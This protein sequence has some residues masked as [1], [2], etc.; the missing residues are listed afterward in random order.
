MLFCVQDFSMSE[1]S[2][3]LLLKSILEAEHRG[4]EELRREHRAEEKQE[5]AEEIKKKFDKEEPNDFT[6]AS[7]WLESWI[8]T[9]GF[10]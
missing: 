5:E 4:E 1:R 2:Y 9:Y 6:A 3:L 7:G 10:Q 8:K